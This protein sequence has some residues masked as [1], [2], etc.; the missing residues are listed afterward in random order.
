MYFQPL[1]FQQAN[2][3][4]SG[5]QAGQNIY[6][7]GVQNQYL[8]QTLQQNLLKSM[9]ANQAA[10]AE[11]PYVG[12][13]A[14][15][16][17]AVTQ[18]QP[19]LM[20]AQGS[21]LRSRVP[22]NAAQAALYNQQ[23][24]YFPQTTYANLL[25]GYGDYARGAYLNSPS[26][27]LSLFQKDPAFQSLANSNQQV[28]DAATNIMTNSVANNPMAQMMNSVPSFQQFQNGSGGNPAQNAPGASQN[29]YLPMPQGVMPGS[30]SMGN[31]YVNATDADK[32]AVQDTYGS[33]AINKTVPKAIQL[34]RYYSN[35]F[36]NQMAPWIPKLPG[37]ANYASLAGKAGL[38]MDKFLAASGMGPDSQQFQ[39]W[40]SFVNTASGLASNELR[41]NMG[42]NSS[43]E[44]SKEFDQL[45]DPGFWNERPADALA[46]FNALMNAKRANDIATSSTQQK[47]L[48][49][50][51][52]S[53]QKPVVQY[54]TQAG[55]GKPLG[56]G[57]YS[58]VTKDGKTMTINDND[59]AYTAK[60]NKIS[61]DE[62]KRRLGIQ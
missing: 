49:N 20:A 57:Q 54:A 6:A 48:G 31:N 9:L 30:T 18:A 51:Q 36:D 40:N 26:H 62:V 59:I 34:Q 61:V 12:P 4:L 21:E 2:P 58:I 11:L 5:I 24:N 50:I 28:N 25:K 35:S 7:Q 22:L 15:A 10:Q 46:R 32:A 13:Q 39:D 23:A 37:I 47:T 27:M 52:A 33:E 8:P 38:H 60:K 1:S 19:G 55:T 56:N 53:L 29:N 17:L 41:R 42:I 16:T 43:V 14:A 45:Q 3:V 44:A